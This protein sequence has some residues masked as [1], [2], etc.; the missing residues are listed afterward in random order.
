MTKQK[1]CTKCGEIKSL[2]DYY[3]KKING[4]KQYYS[5]CK[6][7]H[8]VTVRT[9]TKNNM[10]KHVGYCESWKES[11]TPAELKAFKRRNADYAK[12]RMDS[13]KQNDPVGYE[14]YMIKQADRQRDKYR[15]LTTKQKKK[16]KIYQNEYTKKNKEK[17]KEYQRQYRLKQ[18]NKGE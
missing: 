9:W 1:K 4:K 10:D 14:L 6:I 18:K 12:R 13:F 5:R 2:T 8:M 17:L 15:N 16:L 3:S 7:C 11:L